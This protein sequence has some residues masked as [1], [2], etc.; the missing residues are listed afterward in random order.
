MQIE[1]LKL[2]I[3]REEAKPLLEGAAQSNARLRKIGDSPILQF[4]ICNFQFA[5]I[6]LFPRSIAL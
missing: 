3:E 4:S 6:F 1:N 2:K 5:K